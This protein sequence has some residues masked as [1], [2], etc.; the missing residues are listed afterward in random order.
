MGGRGDREGGTFEKVDGKASLVNGPVRDELEP[1]AAGRALD[2]VRLLVAAVAPD[3]G[4]ALAVPVTHLQVVV[5]AAV[6]AL[7]LG[8]RGLGQQEVRCCRGPDTR[9]PSRR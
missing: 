2:V 5:G 8:G 6:V 3:E 1:Q 7:D 4:A 9:H